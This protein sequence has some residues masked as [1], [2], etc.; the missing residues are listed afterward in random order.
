MMGRRR[1][2]ERKREREREREKGHKRH[3]NVKETNSACVPV[4]I[5]VVLQ[6]EQ[7]IYPKSTK[8]PTAMVHL[9]MSDRG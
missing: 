1:E 8:N 3:K 2:R 7:D 6:W 5:D 9:T 4:Y